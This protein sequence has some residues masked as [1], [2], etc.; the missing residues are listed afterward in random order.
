MISIFPLLDSRICPLAACS[1]ML[2]KASA[3]E[4]LF[5]RRPR[6]Q[7]ACAAK[8]GPLPIQAPVRCATA[9][10]GM[11]IRVYGV[12]EGRANRL[13][14]RSE[15]AG[16]ESGWSRAALEAYL[17][18]QV[19][20]LFTYIVLSLTALYILSIW[21]SGRNELGVTYC[22]EQCRLHT[23]PEQFRYQGY[24]GRQGGCASLLAA[25]ELGGSSAGPLSNDSPQRPGPRDSLPNTPNE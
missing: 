12:C 4:P 16:R 22:T 1:T 20:H 24:H 8:G 21:F 7:P 25:D 23:Y 18:R 17:S 9:P 2:P 14:C 11:Y 6:S 5:R 15:Y 10:A 13:A 3:W 19:C